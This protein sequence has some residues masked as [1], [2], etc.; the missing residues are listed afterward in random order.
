M[1]SCFN[2]ALSE[3]MTRRLRP[4]LIGFDDASDELELLLENL[5]LGI[6]ADIWNAVHRRWPVPEGCLGAAC[7][8][9][10]L[11]APRHE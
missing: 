5:L 9:D 4:S 6:Q 3:A 7:T 10:D 2:A 1:S 8:F 11:P